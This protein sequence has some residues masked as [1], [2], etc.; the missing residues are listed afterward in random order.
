MLVW[1]KYDNK[2]RNL[3]IAPGL[4]FCSPISTFPS[5]CLVHSRNDRAVCHQ[6]IVY[7]AFCNV[8]FVVARILPIHLSL[9]ALI[10]FIRGIHSGKY[11][12][13]SRID[14]ESARGLFQGMDI[15][16]KH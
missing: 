8:C 3:E 6:E 7:V 9:E 14:G 5:L 1:E 13:H 2:N 16:L 10:H 11:I 12:V 4:A 15:S